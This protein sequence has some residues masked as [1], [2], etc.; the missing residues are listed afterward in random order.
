MK[1]SVVAS[2]YNRGKL[3]ERA[4][5][6]YE[7]QDL[8]FEEWE[9]LLVN[10]GETE[11]G[12]AA[13]EKYQKRFNLR[14]FDPAKD[15]NLP[16]QPGQWRDGCKLRNAASTHAFGE[17]IVLTHPEIMIPSNALRAMY[18]TAQANPQAWVTA[19]PFWLPPGE[20]DDYPWQ[21]DLFSL[22]QM[23][24]FWKEDY[25][26][27]KARRGEIEHAYANQY[28]QIRNDWES[29]VFHAMKMS[30]W[31]FI[32]GFRE[33]EKWGSVDVDFLNR[34]RTMGIPTV[35]A[36]DEA[37]RVPSGNLM[38]F[39]QWHDSPR[40]ASA[41]QKEL[42]QA[43]AR[44]R[45]AEEA[46]RAGGLHTV[47]H[48]GHRE[49][50]TDGRLG[51]ILLDHQ[52]RYKWANFYC[53]GKVVLDLGC[54]TGYGA[55][56]IQS[57]KAYVGVDIDAESIEWANKHYGDSLHTF[58]VGSATKIPL[59]SNSVDQVLCFEVLEHIE[60]KEAVVSEMARVL[61][62][63]GNFIV[64]T[65]QKGAAPGTPWDRHM[66]TLDELLELFADR[67]WKNLDLFYQM[68]YGNSPVKKGTPPP[69]AQIV[70]LGGT[71]A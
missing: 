27:A 18:E 6:T 19:I 67:K 62:K 20:Y 53:G 39:H 58:K 51:G 46:R 33:F 65:P 47:Y 32:G 29:E 30:L 7:K 66:V 61:K 41:W 60:D 8:P 9:Y 31:R 14:V 45:S 55:T 44:Y 40:D 68:S 34:R 11:E 24:G 28:L 4:F 50:A 2:T 48:H 15:F 70:I 37:K 10:D 57:C 71:R 38:V 52:E 54:G 59:R 25:D 43:G 36:K 49:R 64:S 63:G 3:L 69:Q 17:V 12:L 5:T 42:S 23:P 26:E 35:I 1:V 22:T 16:K 21:E 56:F 13:I